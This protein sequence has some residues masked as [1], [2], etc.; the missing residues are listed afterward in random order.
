M[1]R[2]LDCIKSVQIEERQKRLER[3]AYYTCFSALAMS[4]AGVSEPLASISPGLIAHELCEVENGLV[5][6]T[7]RKIQDLHVTWGPDVRNWMNTTANAL[8]K[9]S[10]IFDTLKKTCTTA[11]DTVAHGFT[12]ATNR[13]Q[14]SLSNARS[15]AKRLFQSISRQTSSPFHMFS[16]K[17]HQSKANP[18]IATEGE[19]L[20]QQS[21]EDKDGGSS[22]TSCGSV[23]HPC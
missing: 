10:G 18:E 14:T 6:N 7:L 19:A 8:S 1:R 23:N 12:S 11:K 13:F 5:A 9:Y 15:T 20:P 16:T 3:L 2:D 17:G 4:A 21:S 22:D